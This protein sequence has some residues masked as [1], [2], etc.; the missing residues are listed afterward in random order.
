MDKRTNLMLVRSAMDKVHALLYVTIEKEARRILKAHPNLDEFIMAMGDAFFTTHS[1]ESISP[2]DRAYMKP[3]ADIFVEFHYL[4]LEGN[5][6]RFT[7][8]GK[9]V[10]DW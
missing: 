4:K 9:K 1:G 6:M 7:A 2:Y 5:P 3:L 10:T 8:D